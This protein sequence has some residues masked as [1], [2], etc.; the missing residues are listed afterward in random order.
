M[1]AKYQVT[2][3]HEIK[4]VHEI[5]TPKG[6]MKQVCETYLYD[7][8]LIS[9]CE[10]RALEEIPSCEVVCV[11]RS[12][13]IEIV[14]ENVREGAYYKAKITETTVNEDGSESSRSYVVLCNA[15]NLPKATKTF[16]EYL[17]QGLENLVIDSITK[18]KIL[19][20]LQ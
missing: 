4:L 6:D 14:N 8:E 11:A 20:I 1:D 9:Q 7:A 2:M 13:I 12:K 3:L 10:A 18:T 19:D 15:E 16:E 5:E 17:K